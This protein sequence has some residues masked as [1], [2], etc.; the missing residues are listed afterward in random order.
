[1]ARKLP[2]GQQLVTGT[3]LLFKE[4]TVVVIT[5]AKIKVGN[6]SP[7]HRDLIF[8]GKA[9]QVQCRQHGKIWDPAWCKRPHWT[10]PPVPTKL[11]YNIKVGKT[12]TRKHSSVGYSLSKV[13]SRLLV[14]KGLYKWNN[15]GNYK[16]IWGLQWSFEPVFKFPKPFKTLSFQSVSAMGQFLFRNYCWTVGNVLHHFKTSC[17]MGGDVMN[18]YYFA[19]FFAKRQKDELM[20]RHFWNVQLLLQRLYFLV[21]STRLC[22]HSTVLEEEEKHKHLFIVLQWL[23]FR[24]GQTVRQQ[25]NAMKHE[26]D[27]SKTAL[28]GKI[29]T[30]KKKKKKQ[31]I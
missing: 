15:Q 20:K 27:N 9:W 17:I 16:N 1:M 7:S 11:G 12:K 21:F 18:N 26:F 14:L 13:A 6:I 8:N 22:G 29:A 3:G 23:Q 25:C 5:W 4:T 19:L 10:M 24:T 2:S 28:N 31:E 30:M